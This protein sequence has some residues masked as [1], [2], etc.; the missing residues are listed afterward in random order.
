VRLSA[1]TTEFVIRAGKRQALAITL[2]LA[3]AIL[4]GGSATADPTIASKQ[5]EAQSV[6]GQINHID[7]S[8]GRAVE[9]YNLANVKLDRIE[10][11]QR[12]NRRELDIARSS[13]R[14]A[15]T[16]LSSRLV[17]IYTSDRA[18]TLEVLLGSRS[19]DDLINRVETVNRVSD[20]D[21]QVIHDVT[22][23]KAAI[24]RHKAELASAHA[25]QT[26]VVH[27]RAAEKAQIERQLA[28]RRALLAS[29]QREIVHLQ[30]VERARQEALRRQAEARLAAS[31]R[32]SAS[33]STGVAG[34]TTATSAG[35]TETAAATTSTAAPAPAPAPTP[36]PAP[37]PAA[38][39]AHGGVVG[40]A[41]QYLGRP[42]AWGG[43]SP[44]G[45][46]CSGFVMYVFAQIGVSLPHSSYAQF[47]AGV[48]V[49]RSDLQPGDLVFFDGA[50]HVGIY[51][52]GDSFIHSPHTGDVVKISS[53]TGW[54]ASTYVGARRV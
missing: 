50:G 27:Q 49:S 47:G 1:P 46:D 42:Y 30:A 10:Q 11:D 44:A 52:G 22:G 43:A 38:P 13:L 18:S 35:S 34:A 37:A 41:M 40:I 33:G 48:P 31:R 4:A 19:L 5:A 45:F 16:M 15:Q 14:H 54:Y 39:Q 32:L 51:I 53:I 7:A 24:A 29:I 2:G 12:E 20:Q 8:L 26:R 9:R 36:A 3:A 23:A 25:E 21:A 28:Q 17:A 6:L